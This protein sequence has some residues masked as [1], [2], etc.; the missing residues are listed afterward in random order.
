LRNGFKASTALLDELLLVKQFLGGYAAVLERSPLGV[1][2]RSLRSDCG[3]GAESR[4]SNASDGRND[5]A[6]RI[7][8]VLLGRQ[9]TFRSNR[10]GGFDDVQSLSDTGDGTKNLIKSAYCRF[11]GGETKVHLR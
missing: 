4:S 8:V 11:K 10:L 2:G 9:D 1:G 6:K 7:R 5:S 3:V